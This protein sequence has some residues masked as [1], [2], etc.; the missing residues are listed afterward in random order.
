MHFLIL[1]VLLWFSQVALVATPTLIHMPFDFTK[2]LD[3]VKAI[4]LIGGTFG[5]ALLPKAD[6]NPVT[7]LK[8]EQETPVKERLLLFQT[9]FL[10]VLA[11]LFVSVV[12]SSFLSFRLLG[13]TILYRDF[14]FISCIGLHSI[15]A[16]VASEMWW[17]SR[18]VLWCLRCPPL[19][20]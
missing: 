20:N 10:L 2:L 17:R 18:Y 16:S 13:S 19:L 3:S 1:G 11:L 4:Q 12:R 9:E 15:N 14:W 8:L 6:V 7:A 5:V